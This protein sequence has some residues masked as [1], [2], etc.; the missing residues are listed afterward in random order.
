MDKKDMENM[1]VRD[2]NKS[3]KTGLDNFDLD[4]FAGG[5]GKDAQPSG[6]KKAQCET[7]KPVYAISDNPDLYERV[8]EV[9]DLL[10]A[11]GTDITA[12]YENWCEV[13]FALVH[14]LGEQGRELFHR[15]SSMNAEYDHSKCDKKYSELMRGTGEGIG[16]GTFFKKAKEAGI[17]L[18]ELARQRLKAVSATSAIPPT[19]NNMEKVGKSTIF[20]DLDNG[21]ADG[22]MAEVAETLASGETAVCQQRAGYTFSDKVREEDLPLFLKPILDNHAAGVDRDKMLLAAL[23]VVSGLMGGANGTYDEPGGIYGIYDGRKVYAPIYVIVYGTAGSSKGDMAFCK[24]L[25]RPVKLEMRRLYEAEKAKYEEE[26]AAYEAQS[27]GK[28]KSERGTPPKEPSYR[29]LFMPGNS[30]TAA[31]Y[32]ALEAN[33]GWGIILETE[34]DTMA[35]MLESDYGN[36]SDFLRKAFHHEPVSMNRVGEKLHI[37]IENPRL[38]VFLTCTPGQLTGLFPSFENGLGSRFQF[39][40]LP[41]D[42]LEFHDVFAQNDRPLEEVYK[43]MGDELLPLYH[44]LQERKG[45]PI[46]FVMSKAQQREFLNTY[47]EV[48]KE[49]FGMLGSGFKAFVYRLAL[50]HFRYAMVLSALR[51]LSEWNKMDDLFSDDENA[52]VCDDRDFHTAMQIVGCLIH[53]T[54]RVYAVL[55]KENENPF[56]HRGIKLSEPELKLYKALPEGEF[57]T[58]DFMA[59]AAEKGIPERTAERYLGKM[60]SLYGIILP[61]SRGVYA[62]GKEKES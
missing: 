30:S 5:E 52:L 23:T 41:E 43:Q 39:Y 25:A 10:V 27:K 34:A 26:L 42:K 36:Y 22:G 32:R 7:H 60:S 29:D 20:G 24:S 57:R 3:V 59:I 14:D 45:H 6:E 61:V 2:N 55:A 18:G 56:A 46:Q 13:G 33:G 4:A 35:N 11:K 49:Q 38:A 50:T 9:V 12:G 31:I 16:I 48:L 44:A 58:A 19:A 37:D 1:N 8:R 17:D 53:H 47:G 62:K 40:S 15:I 51:R 21:M 28:K 54:A